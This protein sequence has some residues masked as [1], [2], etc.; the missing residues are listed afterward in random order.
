[1]HTLTQDLR[2]SSRMLL[3]SPGF[4]TVA[5]LSLALG[6]GA[7]STM[8][9]VLNALVYRPLPYKNPDQLMMIWETDQK[10][11]GFRR[12]APL[13]NVLDWKEQNH[14]F[15]DIGLTTGDASPRTLSGLGEAERILAQGAS[16][17]FFGLL[18]VKPAL[19]RVFLTEEVRGRAQTVV[20]SDLFWKRRFNRN[21]N[22]LGKTFDDEGTMCTTVGVMP[23]GFEPFYG[24]RI[25]IWEPMD[26]A[27]TTHSKREDHYLMA[28]GRLKPGVTLRQAQLEMDVIARR[29]ERAYPAVNKGVGV[30]VL[31]LHAALF[32]WA[33]RMLAPLLGVVGFVLLIACANVANL[34]LAR[35]QTRR[36]EFVV[37]A[38]L[39]AGR[40]RLIRQLL[41]ESGLLALVG[42]SLSVLL[43]VW[44][45]KLFR[46]L[47][48]EFPYADSVSIDGRV[49][50]FTLAA[51]LLSGIL[52]GLAPALHGSSPDLNSALKE[53]ERRT[54]TGSRGITRKLL[55][56]SEVALA[57]VLLVGAGLMIN[58]MVRLQ[59]VDPGF[60]PTKVLTMETFLSE[61]GYVEHVPGGVLKNVSPQATTFYQQLLQRIENLP[62][63]ESVG[64]IGQLPTRWEEPRTFVI[65]GHPV[66][67]PDKRPEAGYNEVS[68][69]FFH[70]MQIPLKKGRFLNERDTASAPWAVIINEAMARRYF[71][72]EDP[73]GQ[74][75][76]LRFEPYAVEES[77]PRVI[78][79]I[80]GDVKHGGLDSDAPAGMYVSYLQQ[81]SQYPGGRVVGHLR[82]D[83][84]IR[85]G[86]G[87]TGSGANFVASVKR[88][89]AELDKD[90]PV[91]DIMTMDEV[92]SRSI[93]GQRFYM[94]L[95]G[96]VGGL[97]LLLAAV[98]IYGV[99]SYS[100][101]ER[102]H[103]IG[104]RVALGA[105]R[106]D[107]LRLVV[108]L[109]LK[110]TLIGV[111]AGV[112]VA[113]GL[114]RLITGFL[115][116]V[117]AT[118][119]L[120]YALISSLLVGVAVLACYLPARRA[121][122]VDPMVALRYE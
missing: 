80:M 1:M 71:P 74:L 39:G 119:P 76:R 121:T 42:G 43:A 30:K 49:L 100:V 73:I 109:G 9:S 44:G 18:G 45:I 60:N 26:P 102:T 23:P 24:D 104:I 8:F 33:P 72:N 83:L 15:E 86:S 95:L 35:T 75:L 101:T 47:A 67:E 98:G 82:H 117:K 14:V 88:I 41:V 51:S 7:N 107:V 59:H 106:T 105:R 108:N 50:L 110:L 40:A 92:L 93:S 85:T 70:T 114:T 5:V 116:G 29:L 97:A 61:S 21:P 2:F 94:Q 25:D 91:T 58:S 20:I 10:Q 12:P 55:V 103:E 16:A 63:V 22:A 34:L 52:F 68:P 56:I 48:G 53:G 62:G 38:S 113:L 89:V 69:S 99:M 4:A 90:Q 65:L 115:F 112:L 78:V 6:I 111:A 81:P 19:G 77:Q 84:V 13:L 28:I 11:P 37:R 31:P 3:K 79:G 46:Q 27:S 118:D 32:G 120:T 54:A 64:M 66:P 36:K 122:K 87:V 57:L 17:N 96:I